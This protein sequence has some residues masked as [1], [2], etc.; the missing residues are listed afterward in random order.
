MTK[1]Y[2]VTR[3]PF[4][5]NS[6]LLGA[7]PSIDAAE[8]SVSPSPDKWSR[9][10]NRHDSL[11]SRYLPDEGDDDYEIHELVVIDDEVMA[12]VDGETTATAP[13]ERTLVLLFSGTRFASVTHHDTHETA[14]EFARRLDCPGPDGVPNYRGYLMPDDDAQMRAEESAPEVKRALY[15]L[16]AYAARQR[17]PIRI[18]RTSPGSD[19]PGSGAGG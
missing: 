17:P 6:T 13:D 1:I 4:H 3:E 7:Y 14:S 2:I 12:M 11:V 9:S 5:D 18:A 16:R 8:C 15:A 19:V 10:V